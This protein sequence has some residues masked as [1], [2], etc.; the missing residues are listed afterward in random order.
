MICEKCGKTL[1]ESL[2]YCPTCKINE[3]KE[4]N[5]TPNG[6]NIPSI[7]TGNMQEQPPAVVPNLDV[8]NPAPE[9]QQPLREPALPT[10]PVGPATPAE[11]ALA[12]INPE[13][14]VVNVVSPPLETPAPAAQPLPSAPE[15]Q[16]NNLTSPE[17]MQPLSNTP[18][19]A[20]NEGQNMAG[21]LEKAPKKKSALKTILVLLILL[22]LIAGGT[23]LALELLENNNEPPINNNEPPAPENGE[24]EE[25]IN[26]EDE[27]II[28]YSFILAAQRVLT[29][30]EAQYTMDHMTDE[31]PTDAS[32]RNRV[33]FEHLN[34]LP[35]ELILPEGFIPMEAFC[36]TLEALDIFQDESYRGYV[37]VLRTEGRTEFF[38]SLTDDNAS[39]RFMTFDDLNTFPANTTPSGDLIGPANRNASGNTNPNQCPIDASNWR[40]SW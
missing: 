26:G 31:F 1:P 7:N 39:I 5:G 34:D 29:N 24:D 17:P 36:Y 35:S 10:E 27:I 8:Q 3:A 25:E 22:A 30:A 32:D 14:S 28:D 12:P 38:I 2:D 13:E 21:Q 15:T 16:V 6:V 23:Y 11:P 33:R 4:Q 37:V 9:M 19:V 20:A 18:L 40:W